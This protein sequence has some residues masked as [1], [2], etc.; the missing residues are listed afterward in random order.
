[1]AVAPFIS[2]GRG[3]LLSIPRLETSLPQGDSIYLVGHGR[4]KLQFSPFLSITVLASYSGF[5]Y[6]G[7]RRLLGQKLRVIDEQVFP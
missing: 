5:L 1:M 4:P 7:K 2:S 6:H 3:E